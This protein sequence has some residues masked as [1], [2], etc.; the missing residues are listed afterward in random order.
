MLSWQ[1]LMFMRFVDTLALILFFAAFAALAIGLR[2]LAA[3]AMRRRSQARAEKRRPAVAALLAAL[4]L[5]TFAQGAAQATSWPPKPKGLPPA[6]VAP[7]PRAPQPERH[8]DCAEQADSAAW[9]G[10]TP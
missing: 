10:R 8:S 4:A 5:A 7:L 2:S 3:R 1:F 9:T 6:C